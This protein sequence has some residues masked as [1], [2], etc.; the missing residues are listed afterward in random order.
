V[1]LGRPTLLLPS[2]HQLGDLPNPYHL[3]GL[4]WLGSVAGIGVELL[5]AVFVLG[6][7]LLVPRYRRADPDDRRRIRW[8]LPPACSPPRW[9]PST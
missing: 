4:G 3:P 1:L 6:A 9:W 7:V 5:P 2:Y 8:L